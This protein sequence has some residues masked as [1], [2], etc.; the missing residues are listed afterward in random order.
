MQYWQCLL[1]R[2]QCSIKVGNGTVSQLRSRFS[3][4]ACIYTEYVNAHIMQLAVVA[5]LPHAGSGNK[6]R[7]T[8]MI[9]MGSLL[10]FGY[11]LD[12]GVGPVLLVA[13]IGLIAWHIRSL[14]MVLLLIVSAA[15]LHR[16]SSYLELS[17]WRKL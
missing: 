1:Y 4:F 16:A 17:Y 11:T 13:Y 6:T 8:K 2:E 15:T 5:L 7:S 12:L 9:L 3:T 14:P 10:G